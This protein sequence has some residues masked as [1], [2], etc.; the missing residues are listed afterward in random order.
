VSDVDVAEPWMPT[1]RRIED[2]EMSEVTV[3]LRHLDA[4]R[5]PP[6]V[7]ELEAGDDAPS[8]VELGSTFA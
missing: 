4:L 1:V 7:P 3:D 5:H 2:G 8:Q 6:E